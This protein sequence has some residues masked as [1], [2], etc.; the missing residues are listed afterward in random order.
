MKAPHTPLTSTLTFPEL[1]LLTALGTCYFPEDT[2]SA[3]CPGAWEGV[4]NG[5][6][7]VVPR[8]L[9]T[10]SLPHCPVYILLG[11]RWSTRDGAGPLG[12]LGNGH[13]GPAVMTVVGVFPAPPEAAQPCMMNL[14]SASSRSP[15]W[16][17]AALHAHRAL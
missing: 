14:E 13:T 16:R 15:A 2:P 10:R 11:P 6:S 17:L 1:T 9:L 7:P 12:T 3:L 4:S 5:Q 8:P